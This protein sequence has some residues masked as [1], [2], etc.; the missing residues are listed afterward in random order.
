MKRKENFL[1]AFL[2]TAFFCI[3]LLVLSLSGNLKFL[4]SFLEKGTS[5]IQ[6][7]TFH[8]FQNLPFV[9]EDS[10]LKKLKEDNLDLLKKVVD[11]EKLQKENAALSDQFQTSYPASAELL[12]AEVIGMPGFIP[13]VSSPTIFILDKGARDGL[14]LGQAVVVKD[15]LVG[16][17]VKTSTNLSEINLVSN[18]SLSF[19]AKTQSGSQ[20]I[21]KGGTS[22]TLE[23][24]L[25]SENIRA[26]ELVLTK[27][28]VNSDGVGVPQDLIVGKIMS[29]EKNASDLFQ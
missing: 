18:S 23:N 4:T 13:G 27:G 19:T 28:D 21:V 10:K 16:V 3:L 9:S 20:G 15:N 1:P 12:K 14:K 2:V 8:I 6:G 22:L 5:Q 7:I 17:I 26:S 11:S 29:V 24:V 25:L